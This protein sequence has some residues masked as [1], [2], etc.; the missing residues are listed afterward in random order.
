MYNEEQL[1]THFNF[2]LG[3]KNAGFSVRQITDDVNYKFNCHIEPRKLRYFI[4]KVNN[5]TIHSEYNN[6]IMF[7][8]T[9]DAWDKNLNKFCVNFHG[10]LITYKHLSNLTDNEYIITPDNLINLVSNKEAILYAKRILKL[11]QINDEVLID[12]HSKCWPKKPEINVAELLEKIYISFND[13]FNQMLTQLHNLY[14]NFLSTSSK[15]IHYAQ[16]KNV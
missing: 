7:D 8:T 16:A 9:R 5:K 2:I 1:L 4:D 12:Q 6:I 10:L 11:Y 13:E 3:L 14:L 15:G